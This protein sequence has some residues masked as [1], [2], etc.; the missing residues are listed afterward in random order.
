MSETGL[1][2]NESAPY[3]PF[4]TVGT[5]Y[6]G[7][8]VRTG[9]TQ[10][11]KFVPPG[12]RAA[13]VQGDLE[14]WPDGRPKWVYIVT[15]QTDLRDPEIPGDDGMR[16]VWIAGKQM[17]DA[18]KKAV[19]ESGASRDGIKPGGHFAMTFD[20]TTPNDWTD[21]P[22]KHYTA[23]YRPPAPGANTQIVAGPATD[24]PWGTNG[25]TDTA[26]LPAAAHTGTPG[27]TPNTQQMLEQMLRQQQGE[28][29]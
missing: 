3:A 7:T 18:V 19:K 11:R 17:E 16:S 12:Q 26:G 23:T 22:T 9:K 13:G 24:D 14:T 1:F 29:R 25:Y 21:T 4:K 8:V 27:M 6:E 28:T 5:T 10:Q 20:H 2:A 15:L